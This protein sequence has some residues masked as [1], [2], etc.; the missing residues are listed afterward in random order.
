[1]MPSGSVNSGVSRAGVRQPSM[2]EDEGVPLV[3]TG[4]EGRV[5]EAGAA[6]GENDSLATGADD[7]GTDV[8]PS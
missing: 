7:D 5:G 1:M 3:R 6:L 2:Q 8:N 4:S